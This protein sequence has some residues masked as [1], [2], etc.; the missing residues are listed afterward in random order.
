MERMRELLERLCALP[1][2]SG[3]EGPAAGAA[4]ELLEPLVERVTVDPLGNVI[5]LRPCGRAGA[6]TLLLDAHLDQVGLMVTGVQEGFLRFVPIGGIDG[7]MLPGHPVVVLADPPL[8]G[9]VAC[10]P[11]H[12]LRGE[13]RNRAVKI[14]ELYIDVGLGQRE[15]EQA[16]PVGTPCVFRPQCFPLGK[17]Q[18]CG[19]SLDDRSCF[20]CLVRALELLEGAA[21]D[22]DLCV[23]GSTREEAADGG[24][25][26][27]MWRQAPRWCV[28]VDVTHA[29]TPDAGETVWTGELGGGPAVGLGPNTTR[30]MGRRLLDKAGA[31]GLPVQREVMSGSSGTN[32]WAMQISREGVATAVLSLPIKYMHSPVETLALEDMENLSH[33]LAAFIRNLGKEVPV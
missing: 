26:A 29:R 9:V 5:G 15:A 19:T 4:V 12:I 32:G 3:F 7:R 22:V 6:G 30:W 28:A 18:V 8:P 31:L 16:A 20:V 17:G 24:V 33:L 27:A 23:V 25:A 13:E 11:P 2:P 14:E 10:L 1:A 21:L